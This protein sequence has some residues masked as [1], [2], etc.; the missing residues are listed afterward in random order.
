MSTKAFY[1]TYHLK[2]KKFYKLINDNN[3]TYFYIIHF[4]KDFFG[5]TMS[6]LSMIDVGCGV[7]TLSLYFSQY[8]K[9]G[10]GI[11]ISSRAIQIADEAKNHLKI[12]KSHFQE[13]R[14]NCHER[15]I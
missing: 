6:T 10:T 9:R 5:S 13:S 4:F 15:K 1:N 2:N 7:G 12:K 8:L 11:D 3:F 14:V